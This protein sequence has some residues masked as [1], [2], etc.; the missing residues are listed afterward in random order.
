MA[1]FVAAYTRQD[2][3]TPYWGDADD[4][5]ALPFGGQ[6]LADHR[7]LPALIGTVW[8]DEALTRAFPG[9]HSELLW[10]LGPKR[11][12][13]QGPPAV[14]LPA[15]FPESGFY[16]M[17]RN[18]D[19]VFVD[20]GPVG[21]AG[22]GGHGHNDCLSFEA[23]LDR[24]AVVID[25]GSY[26]YTSSPEWRNRFRSTGL[27][28]TPQVDD[29]EQNRIVRPD[30]LW[31]LHADA[32]PQIHAWEPE[33]LRLTASH[34]GFGRL[35]SSVF[36]VR[37][38]ELDPRRHRL[39]VEDRFEGQGKHQLRIPYHLAPEFS[40]ELGNDGAAT[41]RAPTRLFTLRYDDP[42][43]WSAAV[44]ESW[45]APSYGVKHPRVAVVFSHEGELL[46]L[47]VT[48]EPA[49]NGT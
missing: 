20:A 34:T 2:G 37:T 7:Y 21:F 24:T 13:Q 5:R 23:W 8:G 30:W 19:H 32:V 46:P 44:E 36:P 11:A 38:F 16:V 40:V 12:V 14:R 47:R 4:G 31:S 3:S 26:V 41:L 9:S 43:V 17:Q 39:V 42:S 10:V 18:S 29:E 6:G 28:S 15:A 45:F 1:R 22:R 48:I 35:P 25:A 33:A 27:H 49:G